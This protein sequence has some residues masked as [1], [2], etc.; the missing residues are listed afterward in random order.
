MTCLAVSDQPPKVGQCCAT[1]A[2]TIF[3]HFII[4]LLLVFC[5]GLKWLWMI[6]ERKTRKVKNY[7]HFIT[8]RRKASFL[9]KRCICYDIS[10]C[11][12][13]CPSHPVLCQRE[14]THKDAASVSSFLTPRMV[15]GGRPHR[16]KISVQKGR[17][18]CENSRAV[19][20]LS[21][22]ARTVIDSKNQN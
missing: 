6:L 7:I 22:R 11:P 5:S 14:G 13:V 8:A 3:M 19:H 21:H 16:A 12:S 1:N 15:D 18:P 10:V 20:I 17:S 2:H 9:C 4:R